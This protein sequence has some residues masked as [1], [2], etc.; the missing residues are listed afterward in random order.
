MRRRNKPVATGIVV[1]IGL[2]LAACRPSS[3]PDLFIPTLAPAATVDVTVAGATVPATL[4]AATMTLPPPPTA[5]PATIVPPTATALPVLPSA[6]PTPQIVEEVSTAYQVAF[7]AVND[8]LNVRTGPGPDYPVAGE[9]APN[10]DDIALLDEGQTL[11]TG[12]VWVPIEADSLSGWVN[13][14]FL[15]ESVSSEEF[16]ADDD[17]SRLISNLQAAIAG[18][19][20]QLLTELVHPQRGLRLRLN[21]W[22]EEILLSGDEV[23]QLFDQTA[24]Y[25]WGT[26]DGS[27][28]PVSGSFS[29]VLLPLLEK[30][31]V[32][33][34]RLACDEILHGPTAGLVILPDGYEQLHYFSAYRPAPESQ[35][36][37]WGTWVIGVDRWQ[38]QYYLSYL[39]HYDYEI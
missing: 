1:I 4:P 37:D 36:F 17:A 26:E 3:R 24:T 27:G 8:V 11:L 18:R 39:I 34:P 23:A 21:W 14:R 16:C 5:A 31:F 15:T 13:S 2:L 28:F 32:G 10:A 19:D 25:D 9:L 30:D 29:A 6:T 7:V 35:E 38:G 33:A 12:A 22:N 20:S